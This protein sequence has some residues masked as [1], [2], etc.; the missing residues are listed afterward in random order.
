MQESLLSEASDIK[1]CL[2][3]SDKFS[4]DRAIP[5]TP[6]LILSTGCFGVTW[7]PTDMVILADDDDNDKAVE[8]KGRPRKQR[9]LRGTVSL[10]FVA[11]VVD[12][13]SMTQLKLLSGKDFLVLNVM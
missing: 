5:F 9:E 4:A 11:A 1:P 2:G 6:E 7:Q 12:E 3:T 10:T 13:S 8:F